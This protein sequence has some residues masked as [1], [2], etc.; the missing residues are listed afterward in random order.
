M[1]EYYDK[2]A[3]EYDEWWLG[4]GLFAERDRPGWEDEL[5][6]V[7]DLL[8][9]LPPTRTLDV[10]CGTGFITQHLRGDIVGLDQSASMLTEAERKLPHAT[11]VQGDALSLPFPNESF[12]R[13]FTSYFYCHLEEEEAARF[14]D[15]ARRVAS[16]LVVMGSNA[17]PGEELARWEERV[18]ND[19]TRW[20]VYKRV[21]VPEELAAELHGEV[22]HA[23][24]WFVLVRATL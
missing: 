5:D 21:F 6:E 18:L 14:R 20:Q 15:E 17:Q 12:G 8:S 23:G 11:F 22:I 10:A 16:E 2:R 1:K 9:S 13:L 24:R 7:A 4:Q 19:G 3:Q